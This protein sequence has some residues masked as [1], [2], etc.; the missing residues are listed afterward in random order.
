MH[1][2]GG[3]ASGEQGTSGV[4]TFTIA[5]TLVNH[6]PSFT[7]GPDQSVL[8]DAGAQ[9]VAA[10]ATSISAGPANESSQ[11]VNFIVTNNNKIGSATRRERV[12][13]SVVAVSLNTKANG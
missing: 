12:E 8:E 5:V 2:N 1:D 7:K 3:T 11:V 13:I 10:W 9:T 4:Q 6:A